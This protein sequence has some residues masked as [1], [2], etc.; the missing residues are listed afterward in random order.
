MGLRIDTCG[1]LIPLIFCVVDFKTFTYV[2]Q[3][4]SDLRVLFS[5]QLL[6]GLRESK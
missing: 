2:F 3:A 6:S 1:S 4:V 5:S